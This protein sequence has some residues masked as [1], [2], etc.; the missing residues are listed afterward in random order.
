VL[1]LR[2]F[3]QNTPSFPALLRPGDLHPDR[4]RRRSRGRFG[5]GYVLSTSSY[6]QRSDL[7]DATAHI[8]DPDLEAAYGCDTA[9]LYTR[10]GSYTASSG[11]VDIND[12]KTST[13]TFL[14]T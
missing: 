9:E 12:S 8:A 1:Q 6:G 2:L 14:E 3:R 5:E 4:R 7:D 11:I 13:H 10:T